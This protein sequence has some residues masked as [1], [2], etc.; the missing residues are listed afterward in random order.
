[1]TDEQTTTETPSGLGMDGYDEREL[2]LLREG[3]RPK[4]PQLYTRDGAGLSMRG[5]LAGQTVFLVGSGPSLVG[6]DLEALERRGVV[7]MGLNNSWALVR[8]RLWLCTDDP[9][10]FHNL[11]WADP[12]I[13]K[14]VPLN[15]ARKHLRAKGDNGKPAVTGVRPVDCPSTLFF[16]RAPAFDPAAFT[17]L[18]ELQGFQWGNPSNQP[19]ELGHCGKRSSMLAAIHL[20]YYLGVSRIV[21]VGMDFWMD[22]E[23]QYAFD[24]GDT[25]QATQNNNDLYAGLNDRLGTLEP[26]LRDAGC[27]LVNATPEHE[28]SALTSIPRVELSDELEAAAAGYADGIDM[29]G[30]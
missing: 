12:G 13:L 6:M 17:E 10:K 26:L 27:E 11:G 4:G 8:P 18:D 28:Q 7:T 1:M 24:A 2:G 22:Q 29:R 9:G 14:F 19:D 30:W 16:A 3:A 25:P 15:A 21:L 20:L 23:H 5:Q